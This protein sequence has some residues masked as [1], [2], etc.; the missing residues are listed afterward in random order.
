MA[1]GEF[2]LIGQY[3]TNK[4]VPRDDV[5]TGIGDDCA[6]LSVPAGKQ[7]VVTTD[8]MV[9]GIHFLSDADPADIAHKLVA[10]NISDIAAMGGQPAWASLALTLP[11]YDSDWLS[12]FSDSLHLQL[13]RYGVSLIGGDTT[14][15]DMTLTLTLQ[16]FVEQGLALQRHGAKAG[17]LI[18]CSGTIGD[19][20]A[21]LKL[22]IDANHQA[23]DNNTVNNTNEA[24]LTDTEQGFL[25][26]RHQRPTARV[27]TGQ[28]LVG[29]ANSC[30]DLSD[31]L[32]SDLQHI[33]NA[34]SRSGG[35]TLSANVELMALPLSTALQTY[36][37]NALW[38]QYALAGGDDYELLF[39]VS[40]ENKVQLEKV[41]AEHDLPYTH[42]G[43]IVSAEQTE[44]AE[45]Q[46]NYFNDKQ[47]T[48]LVLQGWDHFQ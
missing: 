15:G 1:T 25:I 28:A 33:L 45:Q 5:I 17:D 19:A 42:I 4:S 44:Q 8:T 21:G 9:S 26:A 20:A 23:F 7:L 30:I 24:L 35:V 10:V 32:A 14:K 22:L 34:S 6:I 29:I 41:L 39:T 40:S 46:I 16:G 37:S 48:S 36:V 3:F 2:D 18:Y 38:P 12:A 47:L 27:T 11:S 31:G 43:E 13:H